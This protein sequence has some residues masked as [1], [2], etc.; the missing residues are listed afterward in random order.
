MV[1]SALIQTPVHKHKKK[2]KLESKRKSRSPCEDATP[3]ASSFKNSSHDGS[4]V[5]DNKKIALDRI[6]V[7]IEQIKKFQDANNQK[8][9]EIRD[10]IEKD[11][12]WFK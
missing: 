8:A 11:R 12:E 10:K 2:R 4:P 9:Q 3:N 7:I 5:K 6:E 1:Y